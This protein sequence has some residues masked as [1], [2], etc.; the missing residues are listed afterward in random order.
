M[1]ERTAYSAVHAIVH[2]YRE[3]FNPLLKDSKFRETGGVVIM[4]LGKSSIT[5]LSHPMNLSLLETIFA[6]NVH[7][8]PGRLG[9][10]RIEEITFWQISNI[11]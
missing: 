11:S 4:I 3:F 1:A 10:L 7:L 9:L 6:L 5:K 8:G 2:S